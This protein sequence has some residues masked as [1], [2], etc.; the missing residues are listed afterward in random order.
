MLR[1]ERIRMGIVALGVGVLDVGGVGGK[2]EGGRKGWGGV[3]LLFSALELED[4][5]KYEDKAEADHAAPD[6][7]V[8]PYVL[9]A[10]PLE[11]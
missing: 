2:R 8:A 10:A 5:E 6:F 1:W 11:G 3:D 4:D 9:I 7:G